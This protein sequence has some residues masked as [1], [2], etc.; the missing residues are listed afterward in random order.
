[1]WF[2]IQITQSPCKQSLGFISTQSDVLE[3]PGD[4]NV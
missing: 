2:H 3:L 4:G 1:M